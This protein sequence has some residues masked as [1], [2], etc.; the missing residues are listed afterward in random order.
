MS[1]GEHEVLKSG[2]CLLL[3]QDVGKGGRLFGFR[4]VWKLLPHLQLSAEGTVEEP[5]PGPTVRRIAFESSIPKQ[6]LRKRTKPISSGAVRGGTF[7]G[8]WF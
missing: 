2:R 7:S 1:S 4:G 8:V 5:V 6:K 3:L